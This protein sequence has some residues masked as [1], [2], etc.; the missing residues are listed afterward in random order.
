M[1]R[2]LNKLRLKA[3]EKGSSSFWSFAIG[4]FVLVFLGILIALQVDNWNQDRKEG[5]LER[6]LLSEMLV[7]L[8]G[9]LGDIRFNIE[10]L[11]KYMNSSQVVRDFLTSDLPWHDSLELHFAQLIGG[12]VFDKNST[13]FESLQSIGIELIS[14]NRLRQEITRVYT[15]SYAKVGVNETR[16]FEF[17][18]DHL[19]PAL[20]ENLQ[21]LRIR[22]SAIPVNLDQLRQDQPFL[23]DLS[24]TIFIYGLTIRYYQSTRED[25]MTLIAD[26]ELEL[27]L[28][29]G[30]SR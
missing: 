17:V 30:E 24:M 2:F 14:N 20:R 21:T 12:A 18:F 23:E 26:I 11:K 4:E 13:A 3:D 28:D 19:Y 25:I 9:D 29:P 5:K 15:I 8:K 1:F 6:I 7:E 27:G 22:E 16:L 10:M